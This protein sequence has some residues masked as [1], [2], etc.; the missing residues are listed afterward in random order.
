MDLKF[1][2]GGASPDHHD[3]GGAPSGIPL[4]FAGAATQ[5]ASTSSVLE[6]HVTVA[7]QEVIAEALSGDGVSYGRA[8]TSAV[9]RDSVGVAAAARSAL[10]RV[11]AELGDPLIGSVSAVVL[12]LGTLAAPVLAELGVEAPGEARVTEALQART[13]VAQGTPVR[14]V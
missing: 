1:S 4:P 13:G 8:V 9:D 3:H 14:V 2:F 6:L 5:L 12:D 11:G 7:G 10:A